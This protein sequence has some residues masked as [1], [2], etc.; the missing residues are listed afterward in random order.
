MYRII[1][2]VGYL[3][4]NPRL[5]SHGLAINSCG[6]PK[7]N[8]VHTATR[9]VCPPNG[10]RPIY[11]VLLSYGPALCANG[12]TIVVHERSEIAASIVTG[13]GKRTMALRFSFRPG[14]TLPRGPLP[15]SRVIT[16]GI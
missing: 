8:V 3:V 14:F 11:L 13:A 10:L 5:L 6:F 12:L 9:S 1:C 2:S 7:E 15:W 4:P 16:S